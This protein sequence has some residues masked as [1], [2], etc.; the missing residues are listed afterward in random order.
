[1]PFHFLI[2]RAFFKGRTVT[3]EEKR[4]RKLV[5]YVNMAYL[6]TRKTEMPK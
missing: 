4:G 6:C 5:C 1:M 2:D 3:E